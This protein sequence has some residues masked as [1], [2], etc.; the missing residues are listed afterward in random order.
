[1]R[2]STEEVR[3]LD[4]VTRLAYGFQGTGRPEW[5]FRELVDV[6]ADATWV[7]YAAKDCAKS[8]AFFLLNRFSEMQ[9]L[10]TLRPRVSDTSCADSIAGR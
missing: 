9:P 1:M 3:F 7:P 5:Y 4:V 6:L 2:A 10:T 8:R